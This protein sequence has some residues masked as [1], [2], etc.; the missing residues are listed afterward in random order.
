V[1]TVVV[2]AGATVVVVTVRVDEEDEEEEAL[3]DEFDDAGVVVAGAVL[4]GG[5]A[6]VV[7]PIGRQIESPGTSTVSTD[8]PLTASRSDNGTSAA[9]AS[10]IQ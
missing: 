3:E 5:G 9:S 7:A 6:G 8:A 1:G 10:R 4:V 2:G